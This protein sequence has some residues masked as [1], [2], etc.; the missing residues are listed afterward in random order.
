MRQRP[1]PPS[2]YEGRIR[3]T[4]PPCQQPLVEDAA[5]AALLNYIAFHVT[6]SE[7]H[8]EEALISDEP[9]CFRA[10]ACQQDEH[11]WHQREGT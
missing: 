10:H 11:V 5:V 4:C 3:E 2:S 8:A 1:A 7:R 6:H 9:F